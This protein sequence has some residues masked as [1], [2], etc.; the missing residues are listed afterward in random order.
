MTKADRMLFNRTVKNINRIRQMINILARHGFEDIITNTP[1]RRLVSTKRQ[2]NWLRQDKPV[3]DYTRWERL[4]MVIE[5]LGPT[6]IKFAQLLS[7]RP[8][9]LPAPLIVEFEKL[10]SNVPPFDAQIVKDTFLEET[11][12][13]VEEV[14]SFFDEIPI[15]SASIGQVHRARLHSGE[16]V[17][18]KIQR[19]NIQTKV[20]VDLNLI[21]EFV[22]LTENFFKNLGI[23]NPLDVVDTF[24]ESMQKELN[25][26][27]ELRHL[28]Q[29]RK[30]Y[31]NY[32]QFQVPKPYKAFSTARILTTEFVSG[33]K[34]TD[35]VQMKAW[36]LVP[37]KVVE[38]GLDIYLTQIFEYGFFH[39][40]PHPGNVLVQPNGH[41]VL[42]DFGM[43][44]KLTRQQ[45]YAFAGMFISLARKDAKGMAISLRR[46]A[47]DS[48]IE[49]MRDLED[50]LNIMI[51]DLV[52]LDVGDTGMREF[53]AN[54]QSVIY[55]YSLKIPGTIF[56]ILRS[57]VILEGI[58]QALHPAF[59]TLKAVKP[60]GAKQVAEQFS[61]E[62]VGFEVSNT[63]SQIGSLVYRFPSEAKTILSKLR[64]GDLHFHIEF[65]GLDRI[66]YE[67]D[68]IANRL[69]I[70]LIICALLIFS[71]ISL[72]VDFSKQIPHVLGVSYVTVIG[73]GLTLLL[74]IVLLVMTIRKGRN[75]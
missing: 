65:D 47:F 59:D 25:Y 75:L 27:H 24:E 71:G 18:V 16:D 9:I 29:F 61:L 10:Q 19:P 34:I 41:I 11:K 4:R 37:E 70:T 46:L 49:S 56:L 2:T 23:L 66:L 60:Y 69:S 17:V 33:C 44:G 48:D 12:L 14:F 72:M 3:F 36:G 67:V 43:V 58:G 62:N 55:K 40:D 53:T 20:E 73:L 64:K 31:S 57:L 63:L 30:I 54:L 26:I 32:K 39:A 68:S 15:G 6:F 13:P 28:E 51:D 8:D 7:N 38:R 50:D 5:E 21:R 45:K 1:L 35:I 52:V 74:T 42:I 22:K